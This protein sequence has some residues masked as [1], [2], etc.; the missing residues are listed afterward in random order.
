[1]I[2][3]RIRSEAKG[4]SGE[5]RRMI[6]K[7]QY[8]R[9]MN[10]HEAHGN[11]TV[12]ALKADTSR[13]TARKYVRA[14]K[15]PA[16]LQAKH[17]WRTRPDPLSG[18]WLKAEAMLEAAPELEAKA[19]FWRIGGNVLNRLSQESN[20]RPQNSIHQDLILPVRQ[21]WCGAFQFYSITS[22]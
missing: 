21:A 18:I 2:S 17:T 12:S 20:G 3:Q 8:H 9:L 16:E 4:V 19:P 15:S 5:W 1:M 13:P 7:Q 6:T 10:E 14:G 22:G 11:I